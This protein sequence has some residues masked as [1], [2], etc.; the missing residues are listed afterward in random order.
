MGMKVAVIDVGFNSLKMVKYRVEPNGFTKAYGQLGVMARLGDGLDKTGFLEKEPI[1]RTIDAIRQCHE[2]AT[3]DSIKHVLLVG[4]SPVREAANREEFLRL[5]EEETGLKMRLLSGNEE[6]LYGFLGAAGSVHAPTSLF[7]DLGGGS[8]QLTYVERSRVRKILSLPLGALRLSSAFAGEEGRFSRKGREK[9]AKRISQ[10]LPSRRELG[11]DEDAILVGTGGTVRAMARYAQEATDYP[12]DKIHNYVIGYDLIQQMSREFF[13]LNRDEL[14]RIDAI[15]EDRAGTIAAGGLVVRLVMKRL[16][17][18]NFTVSTHG[19][20]DGLLA[21]FLE[22]GVRTSLGIAQLEELE[23]VAPREETT[24]RG[25]G[26]RELA[27]CLARNG[28]IDGRQ[29]SVLSTAVE[30]G[31]AQDSLEANPSSLFGILMSEDLPMSHEDQL[32]MVVSLVKARRPRTANWLVERY[33]AMLTREDL[34]SVK[35]MGAALRLM[36]I[37]HRS[38][39]HVR[40]TYSGGLRISIVEGESPFPL[41][42]AKSAARGLSASIKR[43]VDI[44]VSTKE[45]GRQA[46]SL[47]AGD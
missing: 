4:T 8:M 26:A 11:L 23:S 16:G 21:E 5:V 38:G 1:S 37:L 14:G 46:E 20:R 19:L 6:A 22:R 18:T 10:I 24:P 32:F 36:E 2:A 44:F 30:R 13:R 15:G 9:M 47:R 12:I 3:V 35:K 42:L 41:E 28:I 40:V 7:F 29:V 25:A 34:K 39:A 27:E 17:F 33:G 31:R 45:V 43:S